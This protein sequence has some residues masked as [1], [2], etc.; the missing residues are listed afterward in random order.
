MIT[1]RTIILVLLMLLAFHAWLTSRERK[2]LYSRIMAG[3]LRDYRERT[4]ST[5]PPV[6]GNFVKRGIDRAQREAA[7]D[8]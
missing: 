1:E 2:D 5:S 4:D 7:N 6:G 8:E 3:S